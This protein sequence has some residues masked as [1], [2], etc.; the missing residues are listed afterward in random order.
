MDQKPD[1]LG[2]SCCLP[3]PRGAL[4]ASLEGSLQEMRLSLGAFGALGSLDHTAPHRRSTHTLTVNESGT[5][6]FSAP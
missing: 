3:E 5:H 1:P 2:F 6:G 4:P